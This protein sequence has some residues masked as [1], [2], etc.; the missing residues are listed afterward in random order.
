MSDSTNHQ[1][2]R[3]FWAVIAPILAWLV[4]APLDMMVSVPWDRL[5]WA[6]TPER[7]ESATA[8]LVAALAVGAPSLTYALWTAAG[9][10]PARTSTNK[11]GPAR[12]RGMRLM[13]VVVGLL[14]ICLSWMALQRA[15][16]AS[17]AVAAARAEVTVAAERRV[18][19]IRSELDRLRSASV[20]LGEPRPVE[21]IE[22]LLKEGKA[23]GPQTIRSLQ[24]EQLDRRTKDGL[25]HQITQLEA[26]LGPAI[27]D[28]TR[29]LSTSAKLVRSWRPETSPEW[30]E[31]VWP[32]AEKTLLMAFLAAVPVIV[33]ML[34]APAAPPPPPRDDRARGVTPGR[35]IE[36]H[37]VAH[38]TQETTTRELFNA[39]AEQG[40]EADAEAFARAFKG[41][42]QA[43]GNMKGRKLRGLPHYPVALKV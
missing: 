19:G 43:Q 23:L 16:S 36:L 32:M 1:D 11:H 26:S 25:L 28:T 27:A 7:I 9:R 12:D 22:R 24:N 4:V 17:F 33:T 20:K 8:L 2:T 31:A 21:E 3:T 15:W 37:V 40:G 13:A 18:V 34:T 5:A 35:W 10:R 39:Y 38:A 41:W 42:R 30:A 29:H 14:A 6:T